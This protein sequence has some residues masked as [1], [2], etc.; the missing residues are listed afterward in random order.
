MNTVDKLSDSE[1]R[2]AY[3]VATKNYNQ[4]YKAKKE[5]EEEMFRRFEKELEDNRR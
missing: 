1:L 4:A 2:R 3:V 5:L